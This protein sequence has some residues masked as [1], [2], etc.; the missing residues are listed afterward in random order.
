MDSSKSRIELETELISKASNG[1]F[2]FD[3][4]KADSQIELVLKMLL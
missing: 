1:S 3:P 4:E 2:T